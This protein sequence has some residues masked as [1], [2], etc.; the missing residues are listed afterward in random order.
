M[1]SGT[2]WKATHVW[3]GPK[4]ICIEWDA[5][6]NVRDGRTVKLQE[7]AVHEIHGGKIQRERFYY[8]PN[9]LAPPS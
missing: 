6:V 1:Q 5:T 4:T 7:V 2:T 3:V 8:D 9:A